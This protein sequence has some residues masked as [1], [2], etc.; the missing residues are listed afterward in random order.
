MTTAKTN[1]QLL[2]LFGRVFDHFLG[3]TIL[4]EKVGFEETAFFFFVIYT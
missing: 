2:T 3:L 4:F 1:K